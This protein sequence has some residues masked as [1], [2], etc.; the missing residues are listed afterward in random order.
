M[1]E[2]EREEVGRKREM[3]REE[4]SQRGAR[5]GGSGT[6][7]GK[8]GRKRIREEG[9]RKERKAGRGEMLHRARGQRWDKRVREG[10]KKR[11]R[12]TISE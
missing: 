2:K 9:A 1:L 12:E 6:G 3:V 10:D 8:K 11:E 7:R 4:E 5:E